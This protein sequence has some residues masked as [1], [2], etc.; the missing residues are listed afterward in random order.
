MAAKKINFPLSDGM[1]AKAA[2]EITNYFRNFDGMPTIVYKSTVANAKSIISLL[3]LGLKGGEEI[4]IRIESENGDNDIDDFLSFL[5][6]MV[7][8]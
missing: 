8:G 6:A 5:E 2:S 7:K 1:Q 3:G 4:E